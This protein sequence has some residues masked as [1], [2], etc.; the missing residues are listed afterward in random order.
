MIEPLPVDTNTRS[1][2]AHALHCCFMALYC[3]LWFS[4][5]TQINV[6]SSWQMAALLSAQTMSLCT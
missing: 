2:Q 4:L 1:E 5:S 3:P 6:F